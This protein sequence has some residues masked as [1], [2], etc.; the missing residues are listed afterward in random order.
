[1]GKVMIINA[2]PRAPK[3]NSKQYAQ[4]FSQYCRLDTEYYEVK[5][6]NHLTLC[7]TIENYSHIVFVFPLYVD[8]IPVPLLNFLKTLEENAPL[9]KPTISV[10]V[11]CGFI[12]PYQNDVAV[13][14]LR[15]FTTKNGYPFGSV[16]KIGSGEAILTTPFRIFL[17]IKMKKFA[18]SVINQRYNNF[19]ATMPISKKMFIKASTAYWENYGK[20]NG[21][22]KEEMEIMQI[23]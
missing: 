16:F 21:I 12:E 7:R 13:E 5:R 2:S 10:I 8:S 6:S 23:E 15:S 1:M 11:N 4:L 19:Q 22:S 18:I 14:M 3:S 17:K 9:K 20:K